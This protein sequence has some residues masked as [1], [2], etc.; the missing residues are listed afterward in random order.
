MTFKNVSKDIIKG[1]LDIYKLDMGI[2]GYT[3]DDDTGAGCV[4]CSHNQNC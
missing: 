1:L 3:W 2:F 4:E